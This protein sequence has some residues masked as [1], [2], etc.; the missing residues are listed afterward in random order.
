LVATSAHPRAKGLQIPLIDLLLERGARID[1]DNDLQSLVRAALAN[2]CPEAARALVSRGAHVKTIYAAAGI[3]DMERVRALFEGSNQQQREEALLVAAQEGHL[4]IVRYLLDHGVDISASDGMTAL[5]NAC[6]GGHMD[7]IDLLLER[8]AELEKLNAFD[9][10]VLSST[11][12]FGR[13]LSDAEFRQCNFPRVIERL[14]AA[15]ARTDVYPE[16][17]G[18]IDAVYQRARKG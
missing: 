4:E 5:H 2:G 13:N 3:G 8:G 18:N 9:G 7:V 16:M 11:L 14:I 6:A 12:W 17:K 10:T 15:G 1:R